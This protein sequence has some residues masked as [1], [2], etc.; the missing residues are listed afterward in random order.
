MLIYP[1]AHV[2]RPSKSAKHDRSARSG[3][4]ENKGNNKSSSQRDTSSPGSMQEAPGA[5]K[6]S[7]EKV[8]L[9]VPVRSRSLGDWLRTAYEP[10]VEVKQ[11]LLDRFKLE[12]KPSNLYDCRERGRYWNGAYCCCGERTTKARARVIVG[13]KVQRRSRSCIRG[14]EG[15]DPSGFGMGRRDSNS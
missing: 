11:L 10:L 14:G 12:W 15:D 3:L 9:A 1:Y 8:E 5:T 7:A 6:G 2:A 13:R 4:D